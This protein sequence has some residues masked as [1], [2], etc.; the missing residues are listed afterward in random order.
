MF[1]YS[2]CIQH[3]LYRRAAQYCNV[4]FV[5]PQTVAPV[6]N[7]PDQI[8]FCQLHRLFQMIMGKGEDFSE[9]V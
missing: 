9:S 4:A 8:V 5:H 3:N 6:L 1:K 2:C 7:R